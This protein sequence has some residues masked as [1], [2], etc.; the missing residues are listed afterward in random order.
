MRVTPLGF[1]FQRFSLTGSEGHLAA[2]LFPLA[3]SRD[4][5]RSSKL[6]PST[7]R[8][9]SK[10]LRIQTVRVDRLGVTR[11]IIDRSSPSFTPLRG[12][13]P[14][15]LG[16]VLPRCLLSWAF[17]SRWTA[18][19]PSRRRLCR[20]SKNRRIGWSLSRTADLPE[21]SSIYREIPKKNS[22][23]APSSCAL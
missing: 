17:T 22:A 12:F 10:D 5:S 4:A 19:C 9:G 8:R 1:C 14:S 6:H 21:V 18:S 7:L 13:H 2:S 15:G 20:V 23:S 3:V 11:G 16:F